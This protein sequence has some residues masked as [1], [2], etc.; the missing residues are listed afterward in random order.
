MI[1]FIY[2][3]EMA[4]HLDNLTEIINTA[5]HLQVSSALDVCSNYIKSLMA[6]DNAE[7]FLNIADTYSLDSVL[8]HWEN[9]IQEKFYEFSQTPGFL[10]L[11]PE[12]LAKHLSRNSL[13]IASEYQLYCCLD[14]WFRFQPIRIINN[15]VMVMGHIRFALMSEGELAMIRESDLMTRCPPAVKELLNKGFHYHVMSKKGHPLVDECSTIR[16]DATSIVLIH[17]GTSYMPFQVTAYNHSSGIFYNLYTDTNGSRDCRIA[18]VDNFVYICRVVDYGGGTLIPSLYRFDP[19]H[20]V[21][22]EL[23]RMRRLRIEFTVVAY[24]RF[25]YAFGGSTE[26]FAILDSVERYNVVANTWE[27]M[28]P[29][30]APTHSLASVLYRDKIYLSGGISGHDRQTMSS[31]TS[32]DPATQLYEALPSMFYA[33]RLHDMVVYDDRVFVLGGIP[34]PGVPLHGQIPIECFSFVTKQWT[35]LSSTLS[36][37]SVGHYMNFDGQIL[38]LGHEHHGATEDEIWLYEADLDQWSKYAKAPHRMSLNSAIFTQLYIN[39][40]EEKVAKKF[41]KK[42]ESSF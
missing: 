8:V 15:S 14:R 12:T 36:G 35:M 5:S 10:K 37:R 13:R 40:D 32:F 3:G 7:D 33:R 23:N 42:K 22:Q 41:I 11:D 2:S 26:Q 16:S 24:R 4:L 9:M 18:A 34:R 1:D 27:D 17:H 21:G 39:F 19:R 28:A 31:F 6:F 25:V 30:P 38:S 20:L 29:I